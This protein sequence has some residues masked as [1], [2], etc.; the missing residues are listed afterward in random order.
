MAQEELDR[1]DLLA[2][3]TAL[4]R[5][6]AF[7]SKADSREIVAGFRR[8]GGL[9]LYFGQDPA[10]HFNS[11][12]QLRRAFAEGLLYK[13]Q[14]G[15]LVALRRLRTP[16]QVQLQS[17]SLLADEVLQFCQAVDRRLAHLADGLASGLVQ[18]AGQVPPDGGV[19]EELLDWLTSRPRP[20][21]I[22]SRP[23]AT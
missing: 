20:V 3:A 1:E 6:A 7:R 19:P 5:R 4:A 23:H 18:V 8:G 14:A 2:E 15:T 22:A 16:S 13:A 17:R 11:A 12:G 21:P 9:S 10:L